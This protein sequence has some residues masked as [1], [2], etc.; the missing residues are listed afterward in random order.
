MQYIHMSTVSEINRNV[1]YRNNAVEI[2]FTGGQYGVM[3]HLIKK[4]NE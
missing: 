4:G 1:E 2:S 3:L